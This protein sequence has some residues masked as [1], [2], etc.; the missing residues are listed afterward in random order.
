MTLSNLK[1]ILYSLI[2]VG[3]IIGPT[4]STLLIASIIFVCFFKIL[5]NKILKPF[6]NKDILLM[7]IIYIY[8]IINLI[9]SKDFENSATRNLG[10][11]RY[12]LLAISTL[13]IFNY[14]ENIN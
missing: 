2:P 11:I 10:F 4:I 1:I 9:L 6:Y 5:K 13:Y 8:L 14:L 3:I 12:V 7:L